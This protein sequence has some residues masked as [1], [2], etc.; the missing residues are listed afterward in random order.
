MFLERIAGIAGI[1]RG[2]CAAT[3]ES[4]NN[5]MPDTDT[6]RHFM[7]FAVFPRSH[8]QCH[9][10]LVLKMLPLRGPPPSLYLGHSTDTQAAHATALQRTLA[11][12]AAHSP[13]RPPQRQSLLLQR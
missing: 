6:E 9:A 1:A 12:S 4:T 13:L 11:I 5:K 10:S 8:Q 3:P 2:I 7:E